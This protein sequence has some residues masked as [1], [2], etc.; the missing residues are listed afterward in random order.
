MFGKL[1]NAD[2]CIHLHPHPHSHSYSE[3]FSLDREVTLSIS[4]LAADLIE[5]VCSIRSVPV[6]ETHLTHFW[7]V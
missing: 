1:H 2:E 5:F 7:N 4:Y 6:L 3:R